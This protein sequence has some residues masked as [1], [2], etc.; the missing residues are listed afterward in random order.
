[1]APTAQQ[2]LG[3][4]GEQ[5]ALEHYKRLGFELLARNQHTRSGEVDLVVA[6]TR[7]IVFAE[8]KTARLTALDP[9]VSITERKLLRMRRVAREWLADEP[10]CRR[11]TLRLD[12]VAVVL[13]LQ[14]RLVALEQYADVS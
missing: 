9:L 8:V 10:H 11:S 13:D 2:M 6:D 1:M 4:R 12:V 7:T 14:D 3:R 5:L